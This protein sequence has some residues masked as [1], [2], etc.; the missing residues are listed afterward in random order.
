MSPDKIFEKAPSWTPKCATDAPPFVKDAPIFLENAPYFLLFYYIFIN[1]FLL[2]F[3]FLA[4]KIA[5]Q[6][7]S[8]FFLGKVYT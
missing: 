2:N 4:K 3:T 6:K 7:F 8:V 5:S 1:K